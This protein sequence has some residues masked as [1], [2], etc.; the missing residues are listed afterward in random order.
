MKKIIITK[1][2]YN[3][4]TEKINEGHLGKTMNRN[5]K[6]LSKSLKD[7]KLKIDEDITEDYKPSLNEYISET[8]SYLKSRVKK[9][10]NPISEFW[11]NSGMNVDSINDL[12]CNSGL[13]TNKYSELFEREEEIVNKKGLRKK[14]IKSYKTFLEMY[15]PNIDETM[16]MASG[17]VPSIVV[18]L[19]RDLD[20]DRKGIKTESTKRVIKI[21][22]E[23]FNILREEV[24]GI[25][26]PF[27]DG[28]KFVE[29]KDC[30]KLN[31]E[32]P[33]NQGI[34]AITLTNNKK[35][36]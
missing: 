22:E 10:G 18:P 25:N 34:E 20:K 29:F 35:N 28:G 21:T 33:C 8:I 12:M 17:A 13:I 24:K 26:K 1:E 9:D 32:E 36:G 19:G 30:T 15:S 14:L 27:Y 7:V 5:F 16:S 3:K 11:V 31:N 23:A 4:I 2:V 6:Q